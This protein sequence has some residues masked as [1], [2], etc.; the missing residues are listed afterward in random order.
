MDDQ[1]YFQTADGPDGVQPIDKVTY[2]AVGTRRKHLVSNVL[3]LNKIPGVRTNSK[4]RA[5]RFELENFVE[6]GNY[7]TGSVSNQLTMSRTL[8]V[9]NRSFRRVALVLI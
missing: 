9:L 4:T 3:F 5:L 6:A 7:G 8:E 1:G 2:F